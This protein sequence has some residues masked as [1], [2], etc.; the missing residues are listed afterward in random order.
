MIQIENVSST[1]E[2]IKAY[3]IEAQSYTEKAA[4]S[5]EAF[6]FRQ[7]I[8]GNYFFVAKDNKGNIVGVTNG[9]RLE[10]V[11]LAD[12]GIKQSTDSERNGSYFCVLTVAVKPDSR[13]KGYG[14]Q[15]MRKIIDRAIQDQ[16]KGILL[17]CEQPLIHFYEKLG[18][19]YVKP[20]LSEHGGIS[21][22]EMILNL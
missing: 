4:A 19:S 16:L 12:E 8:F 5:L 14:A 13:G 1:E 21:W 7:Q 17:M 15:L 18:F 22:H 20:S 10:H 3:E 11:N 6:L 2:A 9:V